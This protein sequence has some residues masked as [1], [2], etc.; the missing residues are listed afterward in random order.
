MRRAAKLLSRLG[1]R[2]WRGAG[3]AAPAQPGGR[4]EEEAAVVALG[5]SVTAGAGQGRAGVLGT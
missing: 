5:A 3:L 4:W 1:R 2:G